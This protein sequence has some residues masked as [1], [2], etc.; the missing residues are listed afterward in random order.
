MELPF[1]QRLA[2]QIDEVL[3]MGE[4]KDLGSFGQLTQLRENRFRAVV[5]K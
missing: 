2:A 5:V 1:A 4:E 3:V